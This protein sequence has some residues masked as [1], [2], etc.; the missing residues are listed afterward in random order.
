MCLIICFNENLFWNLFV[1]CLETVESYLNNNFKKN[2]YITPMGGMV[3]SGTVNN[4][5]KAT[6]SINIDY[7]NDF[8]I[9]SSA[10]GK[11]FP[12]RKEECKEKHAII[13]FV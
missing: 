4:N 1:R 6:F 2:D 10:V 13:K 3:I 5:E 8:K 9:I 11:E 12:E 7:E